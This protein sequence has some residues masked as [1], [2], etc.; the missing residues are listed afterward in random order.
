MKGKEKNYYNYCHFL[1]ELTRG[2]FGALTEF[3]IIISQHDSV[4][5]S[6]NDK[7]Y[8]PKR[9]DYEAYKKAQPKNPSNIVFKKEEN[10]YICLGCK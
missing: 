10:L 2:K 4:I 6:S 7:Y 9:I 1:Y 3:A 8:R 5:N